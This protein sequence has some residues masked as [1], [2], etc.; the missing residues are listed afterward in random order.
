[1]FDVLFQFLRQEIEHALVH[2]RGVVA[3][4]QV[5]VVV[6][7]QLHLELLVGTHERIN[8]LHRVLHMHIVVPRAVD[9][10]HRARE[11]LGVVEQRGIFVTAVV[12][13]RTTHITLG[14]GAVVEPPIGDRR[15]CHTCLERM[16]FRAHR[17]ERLVTAVAP[18]EDSHAA[19]I[20]IRPLRHVVR[21]SDE[22]LRLFLAQRH[23]GLVTP[24]TTATVSSA[25]VDNQHGVAGFDQR[26]FE[27]LAP[28]VEHALTRRTA[29][30]HEDQR[31]LVI[32]HL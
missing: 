1:M 23:I 12:D 20:N 11:V 8:I 24:H 10:E 29:I 13:L 15:D 27:L 32:G 31:Q 14:V 21:R 3:L 9:N 5:M 18:A 2:M 28:A 4:A 7:I 19:A 30:V 25:R 16:S 6:G 22:V 26:I 17:I